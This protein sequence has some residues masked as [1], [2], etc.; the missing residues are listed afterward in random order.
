MN[1]LI[2][3]KELAKALN[4]PLSTIYSWKDSGAIPLNCFKKIGGS[5]F[6]KKLEF[7]NWVNAWWIL[8]IKMA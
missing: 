4:K 6:V 5:W 2:T 1:N 7:D 8:N 3:L